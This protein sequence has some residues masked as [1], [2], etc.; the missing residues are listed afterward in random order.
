M[1]TKSSFY[2]AMLILNIV[3]GTVALVTWAVKDDN[4]HLRER[5]MQQVRNLAFE[6]DSLN[7]QRTSCV[8]SDVAN[9]N[10]N[11]SGYTLRINNLNILTK[12]EISATEQT[13]NIQQL[14]ALIEDPKPTEAK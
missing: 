3:L 2:A 1:K 9:F 13:F 14:G 10:F 7:H 12:V 11:G 5:T 4:Q 8:P 6:V